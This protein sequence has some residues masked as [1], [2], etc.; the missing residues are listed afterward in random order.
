[1]TGLK[2]RL[3]AARLQVL[4]RHRADVA[5]VDGIAAGLV[6]AVEQG[7]QAAAQPGAPSLLAHAA[8]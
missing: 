8:T 6:A 3:E 1:V 4:D 2:A 7:R 5:L